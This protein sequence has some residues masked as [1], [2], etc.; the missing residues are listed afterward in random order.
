MDCLLSQNEMCF[1]SEGVCT[2][3]NH[4]IL[5]T[6]HFMHLVIL[7]LRAAEQP[8]AKQVTVL[9]SV[10]EDHRFLKNGTSAQMHM[11][12]WLVGWGRPRLSRSVA[13]CLSGVR[14]TASRA[15]RARLNDDSAAHGGVTKERELGAH[16]AWTDISNQ[17]TPAH[18]TRV[19][20]H[21]PVLDLQDSFNISL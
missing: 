12:G 16:V 1:P 4:D 8:G 9:L 10:R 21:C 6:M 13:R 19:T 11:L 20:Q 15:E 5:C 7:P 14:S 2:T 18:P 17:S 3:Y